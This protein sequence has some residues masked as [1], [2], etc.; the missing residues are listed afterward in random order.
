MAKIRQSN[1]DAAV[2]TG[3]T[4]LDQKRADGDQVLIYDASSGTIKKIQ[5][6]KLAFLPPVVTAVSP[7][8]ATT[9]DNTGNHTFTIT[10]SGFET[11][12][13]AVLL[14]NDGT[15]VAFSSLTRNSSTQLTGVVAKSSMPNADEPYDVKV[16][17]SNLSFTLENQINIDAQPVF[18]TS[19]G[20]LGSGRFNMSG[21]SVNATDP[22][23]NAQAVRFELQSGALPP[24]ISITNTS[25]EGGTA[26]FT[27]SINPLQSADTVFNFVL[28][29]FDAASNTSSRSFSFTAQGPQV[30]SFTSS[31]TFAVPSGVTAV[32][33]LVVGGGGSGAASGSDTGAGGGGAGG[34]V[35]MPSFTTTPGGTITVT[36]GCGGAGVGAPAG[37]PNCNGRVGQDSSFGS[38]GDPGL[39]SSGV[40][41]A[42][43]GGAGDGGGGAGGA[44]GSGGGGKGFP[45]PGPGG[46]GQ[47][48][49]QP[50]N[51]GAYGFG[52]SGG[53]GGACTSSQGQKTGG[54]GGGGAGGGGSGGGP[55]GS[56]PRGKG[57]NGGAGRAY[58]IADGTTS[59]YYAGGGGGTKGQPGL[60]Q[61]GPDGTA[62]QGGGTA[63]NS[64]GNS[65][66]GTA[67]RGG[68][69]GATRGG[70]LSGTGGKGVV[71]V[72]Y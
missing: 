34:L 64:G 11:D 69:T 10:G 15:E 61:V 67:N 54:G 43:G 47:Q 72:R 38:P 44:G 6:S 32:D 22:E 29:A 42:K 49:T 21:V 57:G 24:G 3:L 35:F 27:G 18:V 4:E 51:S 36:V 37:S 62:G 71:I 9:G 2:I 66:N 16:T 45:G 40:L 5:A 56:S 26:T 46:P 23:S 52:N 58:T 12:V 65:Q 30:Q 14:K 48:S 25:A 7:T 28:R 33:V 60:Y 50:G 63:G 19:A 13:T 1:L 8:N 41:T 70:S 20:S 53:G 68:G 55:N 31:G 39:G 17:S 59:V